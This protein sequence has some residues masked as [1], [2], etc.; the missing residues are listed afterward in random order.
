MVYHDNFSKRITNLHVYDTLIQN[1]KLPTT[2]LLCTHGELDEV[3]HVIPKFVLRWLKKQ[4]GKKAGFFLNNTQVIVPDTLALKMLCKKCEAKFST[5]E[6]NFTDRYFKKYYRS[7]EAVK[8]GGDMYFFALSVAWRILASTRLTN[9]GDEMKKY[10]DRLE[11]IIKSYLNQ[12]HQNVEVDVYA[13]HAVEISTNLSKDH[14]NDNLL[15]LSI[16]QG[17]FCQNLYLPNGTLVTLCPLPLV[18]FKLGAYYFIVAD[19]NYIQS[20][21]FYKIFRKVEGENKVYTLEYSSELM[22]FLN[23]IGN[24]YF[25]EVD[26][27]VIP[28]YIRY[29]VI[30]EAA[31]RGGRRV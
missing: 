2:C 13:F 1:D 29:D 6:K 8:V 25:N 19:Q 15:R 12:P 21:A 28:Q 24:A 22:G 7:R 31:Y 18:H 10:C 27:S 11:D 20:L 26:K 5:H 9:E 30:H 17:I 16:R 23:H 14:Y 3:G 4:A